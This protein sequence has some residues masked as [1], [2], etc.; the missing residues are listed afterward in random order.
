MYCWWDCL[1]FIIV[2]FQLWYQQLC[3]RDMVVGMCV[4]LVVLFIFYNCYFPNVIPTALCKRYG[5]RNVGVLLVV[6]FIFYNCCFPALIPT[7]LCKRYGCRNVCI[8]G[9]CLSLIIVVFQLWYQQLC[10][11]DMVVG[12]C[13]LLVGLFIF[14]NCY[15]PNVIQTALCNRYGCR[16]VCIV[17]SIV[18]L[19]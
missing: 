18:Y 19:L 17:G 4:L 9:D 1:S 15:F 5:C 13:V 6:L 12:M 16:N 14:Y 11:R 2:V 7:A 10:V 3:V 8:V